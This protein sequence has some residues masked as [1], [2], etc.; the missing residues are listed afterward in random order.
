MPPGTMVFS[1]GINNYFRSSR[2][3]EQAL[4]GAA[5]AAASGGRANLRVLD[6]C[7]GAGTILY[8]AWRLGQC[9]DTFIYL[10]RAACVER[11][12]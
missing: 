10:C 11:K 12:P 1:Q 5:V 7:C 8:E 6:P 4:A 9:R 3:Y 2:R